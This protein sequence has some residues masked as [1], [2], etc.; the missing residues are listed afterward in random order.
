MLDQL[1]HDHHVRGAVGDRQ[2]RFPGA[3][4]HCQAAGPGLAQRVGGPVDPGE[5]VLRILGGGDRER[6]AVAAAQVED[7]RRGGQVAQNPGQH[8]GLAP[9]AIRA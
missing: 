5:V 2:A 1:T 8:P 9:G 3:A 4:D 6:G 7:H